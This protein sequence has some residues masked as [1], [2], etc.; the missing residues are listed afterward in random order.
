MSQYRVTKGTTVFTYGFD[1]IIPEYFMFVQKENEDQ[2]ELV[3]SLGEKQGT[4]SNLLDA[5]TKNN[6][7]SLIPEE[8][9][10]NIMLDLPF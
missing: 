10:R 8:H 4:K 2:Q 7:V 6:L 1:R 9:L 3:G 5:I